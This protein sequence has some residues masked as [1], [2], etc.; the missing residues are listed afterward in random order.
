[1]GVY[2]IMLES[3][4]SFDATSWTPVGTEGHC[5]QCLTEDQDEPTSINHIIIGEDEEANEEEE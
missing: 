5:G 3:D 4:G 1:M 2:S